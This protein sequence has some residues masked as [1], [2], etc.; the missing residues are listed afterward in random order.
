M[1]AFEPAQLGVVLVVAVDP[2]ERDPNPLSEEFG[3]AQETLA[4]AS[5]GPVAEVAELQQNVATVLKGSVEE[6]LQP[7]RI[8]VGVTG[9]EQPHDASAGRR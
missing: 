9:H 2:D 4:V 6:H 5:V 8:R 3:A 1:T 7:R